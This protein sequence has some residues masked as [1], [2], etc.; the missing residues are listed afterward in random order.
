MPNRNI[1]VIGAS[2]GGVQPLIDLI[3][4][5][6]PDFTAPILVVV[7]TS[8]SRP[9]TLP[10]ILGRVTKMA[11]GHA[12]NGEKMESGHVYIAP[13]DYH[14]LV[15]DGSLTLDHGPR[16][17][18]TRPAIDPL[19]RSA[20]RAY[21]NGVIG[22]VLSGTLS[23][24]T[25]GLMAIKTYGGTVIVQD[26]QEAL[27][28]GIPRSAINNVK[29]DFVVP[30]K[31]MAALLVRLTKEA[32]PEN[33]KTGGIEMEDATKII[34][35]DFDQQIHDHRSGQPATYTCPDCGGNLWQIDN[36][37]ITQFQCHVGHIFTTDVLLVQKSDL[38]ESA[39]WT[40]VRSLRENATLIRQLADRARRSGDPTR[41]ER[42][43]EQ[44]VLNEKYMQVIREQI[45]EAMVSPV[46]QPFII[47][48]IL[49]DDEVKN[50]IKG[51]VKE[52]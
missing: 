13:P 11:V 8:P 33:P 5:L 3:Q 37:S 25:T 24:G 30:V 36:G 47:D 42:I 6:P 34:K 46:N 32:L 27:Y 45:L 52:A 26:P 39:L 19:F 10:K 17:N 22:I 43:E 29:V 2:A 9:S 23:D 15:R 50:E 48:D 51:E 35:E 14:L 49:S 16:E 20:A 21:G 31:E 41:A 44:A 7:H 28:D 4:Q 38:L 18:H 40:C 1:V 12:Q